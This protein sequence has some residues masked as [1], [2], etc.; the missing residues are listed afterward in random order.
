MEQFAN[1]ELSARLKDLRRK[2]HDLD[3]MISRLETLSSL[4]QLGIKRLKK[5]KLLLKDEIT[6]LEETL[7]P[8]II[9]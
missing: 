7:F 2:H 6:W 3:G 1:E 4:D 9:A 8:D 5:R